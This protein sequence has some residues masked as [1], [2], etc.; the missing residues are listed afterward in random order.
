MQNSRFS[1]KTM[2]LDVTRLFSLTKLIASTLRWFRC[3]RSGYFC[4]G[5]N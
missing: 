2:L 3:G 5:N 1:L 4:G